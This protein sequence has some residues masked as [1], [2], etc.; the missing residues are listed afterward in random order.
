MQ[1]YSLAEFTSLIQEK[2]TTGVSEKLIEQL[3][4][5]RFKSPKEVKLANL[6][7]IFNNLT[8]YSLKK[9]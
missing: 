2:F 5:T 7:E 6:E 4:A 9:E 8:G 3:V 1:K